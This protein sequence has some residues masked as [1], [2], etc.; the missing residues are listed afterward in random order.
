MKWASSVGA[1]VKAA[2]LLIVIVLAAI[3][4]NRWERSNLRRWDD[5]FS[6]IYDDRLVPETY[7]FELTDRLYRKR[8]L[9][10]GQDGVPVSA[11]PAGR[12]DAIRAVLGKHDAE[13]DRLVKGFESTHL[14]DAE[15]RALRGLKARLAACRDLEQRWIAAPSEELRVALAVE[16]D[17]ALGELRQLSRIQVQVGQELKKDSKTL[18]ASS[19]FLYQLEMGLLLVMGLLIQFLV[20][21]RQSPAADEPPPPLGPAR[22]RLDPV[23]SR[24]STLH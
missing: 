16:S 10:S 2:L 14:V 11:D 7:V 18:L 19:S 21:A 12:A 1:R 22:P 3:L 4:N 24:K 8:L 15:G 13:I 20:P 17:G 5:S 6:S 9:W 23:R